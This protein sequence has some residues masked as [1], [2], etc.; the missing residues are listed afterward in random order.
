MKTVALLVTFVAAVVADP[1]DPI[2]WEIGTSCISYG[3]EGC[4]GRGLDELSAV[5]VC[6]DQ[7]VWA[8]RQWCSGKFACKEKWEGGAY[9]VN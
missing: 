9:C 2:N 6:S 4:G 7:H 1:S 5:V 3:L 8:V